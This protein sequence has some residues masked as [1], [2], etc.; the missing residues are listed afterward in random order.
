MNI[1]NR[2][3]I[4]NIEGE[5]EFYYRPVSTRCRW[6]WTIKRDAAWSE[7]HHLRNIL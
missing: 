7:G 3:N 4:I 2:V 5:N 1:K 6:K